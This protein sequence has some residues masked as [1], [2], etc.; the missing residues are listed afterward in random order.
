MNRRNFIYLLGCGCVS[1]G[2]NACTTTPITDRRQ[3]KLLPEAKDRLN[4]RAVVRDDPK[5]LI[6]SLRDYIVN[7]IY[8][9]DVSDNMFSYYYSDPYGDG[10]LYKRASDLV[11]QACNTH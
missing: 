2:L 9:A 5:E 3:L 8:P 1:F 11:V 7:G 4:K 10:N 6:D